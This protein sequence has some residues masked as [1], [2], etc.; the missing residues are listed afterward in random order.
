L[1]I[2]YLGV[3]RG[4]LNVETISVGEFPV[5]AAFI[6]LFI[7]CVLYLLLAVLFEVAIRGVL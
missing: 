5:Y 2:Q 1:Q 4:G 7:D 6:M 3:H